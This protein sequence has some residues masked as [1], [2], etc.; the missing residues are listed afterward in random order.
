MWGGRDRVLARTDLA[1]DRTFRDRASASDGDRAEL[2]QCHGVAV[3]RL[4]R[5]RAAA[6]RHGADEGDD[7]A[8]RRPHGL[9]GRGADVDAAVLARRVLVGRERERAQERSV[10]G[11][12]P[13]GRNG[14]DEKRRDRCNDRGGED[15]PHRTPPS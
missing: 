5:E 3:D 8:G 12:G 4:D 13:A 9:A 15:A 10:G 14:D 6:G 1:D 11:P 7:A 2:E